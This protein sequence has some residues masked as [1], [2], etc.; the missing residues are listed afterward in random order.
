M[1][2]IEISS[3]SSSSAGAGAGAVDESVSTRSAAMSSAVGVW[4]LSIGEAY[5]CPAPGGLPFLVMVRP[6]DGPGEMG[7]S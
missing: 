1:P 3:M 2:S 6:V 4:V 7:I 5:N